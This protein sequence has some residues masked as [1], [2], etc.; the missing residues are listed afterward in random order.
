MNRPEGSESQ[1]QHHRVGSQDSNGFIQVVDSGRKQQ[2][3]ACCQLLIDAGRGVDAGP[4]DIELLEW[5]RSA[6]RG[7]PVPRDACAVSTE[8][9][10]ADTPFP[11]SIYLEERF[12]PHDWRLR[13]F[14]VRRRW[15]VPLRGMENPNK[16][17]VPVRTRPA[18]PFAVARNP[19]LLTSGIDVA[20]DKS[21]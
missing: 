15:P 2:M 20:I 11:L 4:R 13:D 17:H 18:S 21:V 6:R 5:N 19:L 14:R 9:R 10:N 8:R 1:T 3:L 12:L 16:T 7:P